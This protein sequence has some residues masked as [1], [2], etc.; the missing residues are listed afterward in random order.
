MFQFLT[1]LCICSEEEAGLDAPA[2]DALRRGARVR[3]INVRL[4]DQE[5]EVVAGTGERRRGEAQNEV[6]IDHSSVEEQR[7]CRAGR[8][9]GRGRGRGGEKRWEERSTGREG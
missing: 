8:G 2:A 3:R 7:G 4:Q 5:L 9:G 6:P 1:I